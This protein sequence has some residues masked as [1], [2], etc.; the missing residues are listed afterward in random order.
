[1]PLRHWEYRQDC[2]GPYSVHPEYTRSG[3]TWCRHLYWYRM[4]D[5]ILINHPNQNIYIYVYT[6]T[7][8]QIYKYLY[9]CKWDLST[10]SVWTAENFYMTRYWR[11]A[12]KVHWDFIT[13]LCT[14]ATEKLIMN[15]QI[16]KP[17]KS[18]SCCNN[19]QYKTYKFI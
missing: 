19:L 8:K 12:V 4:P 5:S 15:T 7:Q 6:H 14:W 2:K 11:S 13:S 17:F 1:M 9:T 16:Q 3:C 18:I 10:S